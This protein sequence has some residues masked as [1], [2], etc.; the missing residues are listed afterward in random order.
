MIYEQLQ[1]Y[2]DCFDDKYIESDRFEKDVAELVNLVSMATCWTQE[3]CETFL[4]SER[5][6]VVNL[7]DCIDECGI[8][9]FAPFYAPFVENSFVFTLVE[10]KGIEE[11][12]IELKQYRYSET[13]GNFKIEL[14]LPLCRCKTCNCGCKSVYKLVVTYTAGYEALPDC[15]LPVFCNALEYIQTLNDCGCDKC[16]ACEEENEEIETVDYSEA[17]TLHD[18]LAGYFVEV[19]EEQFKRQLS[20]ISLCGNCKALWGKVV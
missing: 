8:F 13:D 3:P 9:A 12:M 14:P 15:L 20:L 11:T 10:Q 2:C 17:V 16:T 19:I 6:E 7:P 4:L 18:R 5:R 1:D